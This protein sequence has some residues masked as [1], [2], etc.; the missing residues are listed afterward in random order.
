MKT[1]KTVKQLRAA[2]AAWRKRGL[3]VGFVPTMG[4]LHAGHQ[5]LIKKAAAQNDRT[6][7]SIFVN[8]MQ[9]GP[10]EDLA[11]YPRDLAAD[12]KAC[13]A[14]GAHLIFCPEAGEMYPPAFAARVEISGVSEGLCGAS[15]PGHFT[16][17]AT[18]VAKLFNIV[19]AD[20]AYFGQ[21]DAQQLAVIRRMAADLNINTRIIS[22]PIVRGSDGLALS[23]R[24][25]YLNAR[26][27]Q[28]ALCIS[29]A[30]AAGRKM[31]EGGARS[32]LKVEAAVRATI[33]KEPLAKIDYVKIVDPQTMRPVR[34]INGAV[35]CAAAVFIGKTRLID[36]FIFGA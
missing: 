20:R 34:Q 16:G 3:S 27:R 28:A 22:C 1:V 24:N 4:F 23:S 33:N 18:V 11:K 36:N 19:Q 30:L 31:L 8:P 32:A 12:K 2:V 7:V 5:S 17:V 15:R 25:A 9:F 14:A 13:A 10:K 29:R 21:K 6:V 35:L 26:E